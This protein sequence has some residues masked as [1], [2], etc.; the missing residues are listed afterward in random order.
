MQACP[1]ILGCDLNAE[2]SEPCHAALVAPEAAADQPASADVDAAGSG[3]GLGLADA[4]AAAGM[5][6]H[7]TSIKVRTG[8]YKAGRAVYAVDYILHSNSMCAHGHHLFA[9]C[10]ATHRRRLMRRLRRL[11]RRWPRLL[12]LLLLPLLHGRQAVRVAL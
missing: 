12:Q 8:S 4:Y 7:P 9:R 11:L 1:I 6:A 10:V 5:A 2:R 3:G